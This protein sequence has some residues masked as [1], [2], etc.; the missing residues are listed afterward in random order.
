MIGE[1]SVTRILM[2]LAAVLIILAGFY[3]TK[4]WV[5]ASLR[6]SNQKAALVIYTNALSAC[7]RANILRKESNAR[8]VSNQA[9]S[10]VIRRFLSSASKARKSSYKVSHSRSDLVAAQEYDREIKV[11]DTQVRFHRTAV[12]NCKKFVHDPRIV[13]THSRH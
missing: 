11:L 7:H 2:F 12:V 9:Q 10:E 4:Q 3:G 13:G 5:G 8:I 1:R 6:D